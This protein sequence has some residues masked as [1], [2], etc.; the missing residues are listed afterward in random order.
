QL[1]RTP[2]DLF[3]FAMLSIAIGSLQLMLDRGQLLDWFSSTEI[4]A[5]LVVSAVALY[6]FIVHILTT[7]HPFV[8]PALF[9]DRN[10]S[11][12]CLIIF[13]A[14]IV[15]LATLALMPP[16]LAG[17]FDYPVVTIGLVTAPRGVGMLL[18]MLIVGRMIS[19]FDA[20]WLMA[21]GFSAVALSL[22]M[23]AGASPQMDERLVI[24]SGLIQGFGLGFVWVPLTTVAF[25]TLAVHFRNEGTALFNLLR[26]IGSSVGIA[27][28][29]A[30]VTR[31]TTYM[32]ARLAE[33]VTPY[34]FATRNHPAF[35]ATTLAGLRA[36]DGAVTHQ[37]TLIAYNNDFKLL[38]ILTLAV[39]PLVFLF[40]RAMGTA[41]AA[42]HAD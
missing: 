30:L 4:V 18:A 33:H 24:W 39:V 13:I 9:R 8:S 1:K 22:W 27:V 3:G 15:M 21:F 41:P 29:T 28:V 40:R 36:I 26:N 16:L 12:G 17:V 37:A 14:G 2:F 11:L 7:P 42:V 6:L 25:G 35:D 38:F 31:N 32:H 10:F 19:K 20:R 5:E 23:M 34:D